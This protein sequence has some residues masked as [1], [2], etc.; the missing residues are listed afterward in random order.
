MNS[1]WLVHVCKELLLYTGI[2][3]VPQAEVLSPAVDNKTQQN[4]HQSAPVLEQAEEKKII[5]N[6]I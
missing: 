6:S 2:F 1:L 3:D 5:S 4:A